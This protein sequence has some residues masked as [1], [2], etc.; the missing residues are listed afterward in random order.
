MQAVLLAAGVAP[1]GNTTLASGGHFHK[2]RAKAARADTQDAAT[3]LRLEMLADNLL[4]GLTL[5]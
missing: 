1:D 5:Y 2:Y 4:N 3:G